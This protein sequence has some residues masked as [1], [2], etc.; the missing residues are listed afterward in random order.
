[1]NLTSKPISVKFKVQQNH[2]IIDGR[3][4]NAGNQQYEVQVNQVI[5]APNFIVFDDEVEDFSGG[6]NNSNIGQD[7]NAKHQ[8]T[9]EDPP[10]SE[11]KKG[12]DSRPNPFEQY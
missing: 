5:P 8:S 9:P 1:V 10:S 2:I 12:S 4:E 7:T 6:E 11:P 3:L